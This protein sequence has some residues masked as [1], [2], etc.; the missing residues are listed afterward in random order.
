MQQYRNCWKKH[1]LLSLCQ[2][3]IAKTTRESTIRGTMKAP[4]AIIEQSVVMDPVGLGTKNHCAGEGQQ[5]F[6]SHSVTQS[7]SQSEVRISS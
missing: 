7:V 6:N 5:Q 2:G 1:F 4:S 3:N